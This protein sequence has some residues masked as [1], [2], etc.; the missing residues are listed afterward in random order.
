MVSDRIVLSKIIKYS[1]GDYHLSFLKKIYE[2]KKINDSKKTELAF[3][4]GKA[5]EDINDFDGSFECYNKGNNLR[6][7]NLTFSI[8][9]ERRLRPAHPQ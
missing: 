9:E 1:K 7:K 2:D 3:A 5:Y 4:L 8:I 6:R